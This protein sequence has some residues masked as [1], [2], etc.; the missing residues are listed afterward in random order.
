MFKPNKLQGAPFPFAIISVGQVCNI[1]QET[2]EIKNADTH[3][4]LLVGSHTNV[5][6]LR[7]NHSEF[8]YHHELS[9]HVEP[10]TY[11]TTEA[12]QFC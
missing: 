1:K 5:C 10:V 2:G 12:D 4:N 11:K 6:S 7:D 3:K 9:A 8:Y